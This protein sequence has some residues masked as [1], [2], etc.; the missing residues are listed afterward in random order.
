MAQTFNDLGLSEVALEAIRKKG[1]EEPTEIQ[2]KVIPLLLESDRDVIA[3]AQTGTGKTATF[4]LVFADKL[5]PKKSKSPQAIVLAPTRELAVQVSVEL[6]SLKGTQNFS[7]VPIYGGQSW[8]M[9]RKHLQAGVDI[10]VGTPGRVMDHLEKGTLKLDEIE[11]FVLDEA[12]EML[13]MGFVED[14]EAILEYA[15]PGRQVLLFSATMPARIASLAKK[16]MNSPVSI[17]TEKDQIANNSVDQI[18][19]EASYRN[20]FEALCRIVDMEDE[21]YG[22][23]FCRTK[24]DSNDVAKQL[25]DRG[26]RAEAFHGDISQDRREQI[27]R[28]FR[29]RKT[30]ILVATDVAARGI[31]VT[32]LSHVINYS[33]PQN[34]ESYVHRI[35]R[36]GRAGKTGKA[37]TLIT[38]SEYR[39]LRMFEHHAKADIQQQFIPDATEMVDLKKQKILRQLDTIITE[40]G[41]L[42]RYKKLAIEMFE[43]KEPLEI[44]AALL[45]HGF[46]ESLDE[47]AYSNIQEKR[48]PR[49][50]DRGARPPRGEG[51][52][53]RG[54]SGRDRERTATNLGTTRLF[55]TTGRKDGA[56]VGNILQMVEK[57]FG[58]AGKVVGDIDI[59]DSY[60][61][62]TVPFIDAEAILDVFHQTKKKGKPA[63][64]VERVA[65]EKKGRGGH[66]GKKRPGKGGMKKKRR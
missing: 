25:N 63:V 8:G 22:I 10:V 4:G 5:T 31:D 52:R 33:L 36:T 11:Y 17:K 35:G 32:D 29:K 51:G 16:Y 7:I 66:R 58:V 38:P 6:N 30:E 14:I 60:S 55:L 40:A 39:K 1:F 20:K 47:S 54:D 26:Y 3:Q 48:V 50:N 41:T 42:K 27:L 18:Y 15:K 61:F 43:G 44:I 46:S 45:K 2:A 23:I 62:I 21:F 56:T 19:F 65:H 53:N 9:Q 37:I 28:N 64:R 59:M 24:I 49:K 13:N 34:S 57:D 12:D